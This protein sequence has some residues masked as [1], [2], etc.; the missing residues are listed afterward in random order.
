MYYI[1]Y[2][3]GEKDAY[4]SFLILE[5]I[6]LYQVFIIMH[7]S[8]TSSSLEF[9]SWGNIGTPSHFFSA[10]AEVI[11]WFMI[12]RELL[13]CVTPVD[14]GLLKNIFIPQNMPTRQLCEWKSL[15]WGN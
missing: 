13:C 1:D 15:Q 12:S 8:S 3:W 4:D 6:L 14:L 11:L 10:T 5:K 2:E 9:L 7:V